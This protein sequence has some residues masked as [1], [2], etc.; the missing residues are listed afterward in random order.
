MA[1]EEE[2]HQKRAQAHERP[3][4]RDIR[5]LGGEG[6]Q[7]READREIKKAPQHI[8]DGRGV[9]DAGRRGEGSGE[10]VPLIPCTKWGTPFARNRPAANWSRK[11]YQG[12]LNMPPHLF[13]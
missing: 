3:F 1:R 6:E 12:T 7:K 8:D 5:A 9:A 4:E 2:G 13:S 11:M 10:G